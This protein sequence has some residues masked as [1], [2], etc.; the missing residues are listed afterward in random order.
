[1]R[2]TF[3]SAETTCAR[4]RST[5]CAE[6]RSWPKGFSMT[7]RAPAA[8]PDSAELTNH[9]SRRGSAGWRDSGAGALRRPAGGGAVAKVA[10]SAI[11]AV[12]VAQI[13]AEVQRELRHR[14]RRDAFEAVRGALPAVDRA[15]QPALAT[16]ITGIPP[17]RLFRRGSTARACGTLHQNNSVLRRFRRCRHATRRA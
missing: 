1:M 11:V 16:P 10:A 8:Q 3:S 17:K 4:P 6:A 12:D 2:K 9:R 5:A 13:A 15:S 14:G 7:T